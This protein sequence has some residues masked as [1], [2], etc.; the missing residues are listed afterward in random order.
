MTQIKYQRRLSSRL[1]IVMFRGTTC[2][3]DN[4]LIVRIENINIVSML[5]YEQILLQKVQLFLENT[6]KIG[7]IK[8]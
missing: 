2:I 6:T 7:K 3:R 8:P 4:V 1:A 5:S